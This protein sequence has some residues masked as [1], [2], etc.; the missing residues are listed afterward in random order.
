MEK[1]KNDNGF[2]YFLLKTKGYKKQYTNE[3]AARRAFAKLEKQKME[4]QEPF[5]IELFG[6]VKLKDEWQELDYVS[7]SEFG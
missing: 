6:K 2:A 1:K 4:A 3:E 5:K 7:V